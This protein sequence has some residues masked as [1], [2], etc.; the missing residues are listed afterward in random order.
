[1]TAHAKLW[2]RRWK[3]ITM[4]KRLLIIDGNSLLFR[5][6]YAT[7]YAG[8]EK[9]M[10]TSTGQP[11]NAIFAFANMMVKILNDMKADDSLFVAFDTGTK[12]FRH[13]EYDDYKAGRQQ[14]PDELISQFAI[15][16]EFLDALNIKHHEIDGFEADDLAGSLALK[17]S[18]A[19]YNVELYTSDQDY[20]Q[21]IS[22]NVT[23]ELIKKGL[24]DVLTLTPEKLYEEYGFTPNQVT[25]FKG[26][27]GDA[28]DNLKGIPGVGKVTALKLLN[29]YDNL[30]NIIANAHNIKGKV[31]ENIQQYASVAQTSK[32]LATIV[33]D[34]P[35][36]DDL[37]LFHYTGFDS[38][39][40]QKFA[41]KYELRTF[42][43]N[44][45]YRSAQK[46]TEIVVKKIENSTS[47]RTSGLKTFAFYFDG[48]D[49]NYFDATLE[50]IYFKLGDVIYKMAFTAFKNAPELLAILEDERIAKF[51]HDLKRCS[52]ML[53]NENITLRGTF[54][55]AALVAYLND[56]NANASLQAFLLNF[57]YNVASDDLLIP[58]LV[59]N[60]ENAYDAGY[61]RLAKDGLLKL[62]EDIER[63]LLKVLI[64][65]E[66]AGID[67]DDAILTSIG[68]E[69]KAIIENLTREI[70]LAA[71]HEFNINSPQ[72]VAIVLFDELGLKANRKRSTAVDILNELKKDH[73][74]IPLILEYRKYQ[75]IISNYIDG[76][77]PHIHEDGKI[78]TSFNQLLTTTGRLS[79][80][81]PNLQN[82]SVRAEE[83]REVRKAFYAKDHKL[84]A[85]DYSQIELRLL[86]CIAGSRELIDVFNA[87][88]DI[89]A[90]TAMRLFP[91]E[92]LDYS[93]R[94]AKAVNF[95]IVYGISD[96]GLAEQ[97][98]ISVPE[99]RLII[100][101]FYE[102]YPEIKT[103][104]ENIIKDV[105]TNGFVT[106]LTG[107]KRYLPQINDA[108]YQTREFAKRAAMNAPIQ[109][110]AADLIKLAMIK[111][112]AYLEEG[113][114]KTKLLLQVHDELIFALHHDEEHIV[115]DIVQIMENIFSLPLKLKVGVSIGANW[116]EAS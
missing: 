61:K 5:A 31:G 1:M 45:K 50:N 79:S 38:S 60:L 105:Q 32:Y 77:M 74:I 99:A 43:N 88:R 59:F 12:T 107:R 115:D 58:T 39:E 100:S 87:D 13:K 20:F 86:A 65:M 11:T 84:L 66:I 91:L 78:H 104:R 2:W 114:Y 19:G 82:I 52:V 57:G 71:G 69:Y 55:D 92:D 72:Q 106:T 96:F 53:A 42:M 110:S 29:E 34:V 113:Q 81:N 47:L 101:M 14:V 3:G 63:P 112:D 36:S 62:Y 80:N 35:I 10:R 21:L 89:H 75:K 44:I 48:D 28:S 111:V 49:P 83:G 17:A 67:V 73:I 37:S 116:F 85:I 70:Y 33:T 97:L 25:D 56:S 26:L 103:Y 9:I 7:A 64:K 30:E 68:N 54:N 18:Q 15:A 98:D 4:N 94:K 51:G 6:Y 46:E 108:N 16:R 40:V 23:V 41:S 24:S 109:G 8:V 93:R 22:A 95:G 90:E 76:L 27:T 102:T